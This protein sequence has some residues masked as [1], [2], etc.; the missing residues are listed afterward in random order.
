MYNAGCSNIR[1]AVELFGKTTDE[2]L[3]DFDGLDQ[4]VRASGVR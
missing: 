2:L 1:V 4:R 3:R